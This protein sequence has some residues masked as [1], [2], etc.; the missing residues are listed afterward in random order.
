M[1]TAVALSLVWLDYAVNNPRRVMTG[2]TVSSDCCQCGECWAP[3]RQECCDNGCSSRHRPRYGGTLR[4][5]GA[6]LV[7]ADIN[8]DGLSVLQASLANV[9]ES[10]VVLHAD[11]SQPRTSAR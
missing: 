1:A 4:R 6:R 5:E 3:D 9:T 7:L 8:L 11:V 10:V 2:R